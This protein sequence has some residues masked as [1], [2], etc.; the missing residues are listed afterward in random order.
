MTSLQEIM[1]QDVTDVF[2][3]E[4]FTV[5][6]FYTIGGVK[7]EIK[8][9]LFEE[10]LDKMRSN[11]MHAWC[12]YDDVA[13]LLEEDDFTMIINDIK[14]A[15]LDSTPDEFYHGINLFLQEV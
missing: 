5:I 7:K 2:L 10:S 9:Q 6:A 12:L 13:D 4:D 15:I 1:K 3:N 14:Y 8:V 11:Y